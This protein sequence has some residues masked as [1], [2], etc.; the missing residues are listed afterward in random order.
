MTVWIIAWGLLTAN[1]VTADTWPG[2]RGDGSAVTPA[3]NL[4]VRWT[5]EDGVAW[6]VAVSGYGQSAPVVWKDRVFVTSVDGPEQERGLVHAYHLADGQRLWTRELTA[7]Q[8]LENMFRNSR[9]ASTPVVDA[10]GIYVLFAGGQLAGLTHDG[11]IR[12][13]RCLVEQ[14]GEF[15]NGRGLSSSLAQT[16]SAVIALVDHEGPSY[17]LAVSKQTGENRWQTDRGTRSSSWSSPLVTPG[18]G[19]PLVILSSSGTIEALDGETGRGLWGLRGLVGNHIPSPGFS[20]NR[21]FVGACEAEHIPMNPRDI[22]RS[23]CCLSL[24]QSEGQAGV[25]VVWTARRAVSYYST[26]LAYRGGVYYV[27][28]VGV[29]YCLDEQTGEEHY[30]ERIGGPCWASAIGAGQYVYLFLKK[31]KVAVIRAGPEF[32]LVA[33]NRVWSEDEDPPEYQPLPIPAG[34]RLPKNLPLDLDAMDEGL[35][36]RIFA[37]G[38]PILYGA[39][40]VEGHLLLRTG[41]ALICVRNE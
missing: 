12:W 6:R 13:Q 19:R 25:E 15:Q 14:Y 3:E 27:N 32:E 28:K 18:F 30:V 26:P 2:F 5:P 35:L 33:L 29:L 20:G 9:A 11:E 22:S 37:Y 4:P 31:G 1:P 21:I 23:N 16:G 17:A 39:A 34:F 38:D 7:T 41:E 36:R 8:T 10:D 24:T 40:A